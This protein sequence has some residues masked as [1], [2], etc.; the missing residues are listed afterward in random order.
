MIVLII[1]NLLEVIDS[2]KSFLRRIYFFR[3]SRKIAHLTSSVNYHVAI[4]C[5]FDTNPRPDIGNLIEHLRKSGFRVLGVCANNAYLQ[6]KDIL[7][8]VVHIAPVGRDFYAYQQGWIAL[9][10]IGALK[11][12][13]SVT[14]LND[15]VWYFNSQQK[16]TVNNLFEKLKEDQLVV[17]S[18]IYDE[19]PHCSG[20]LFGTSLNRNTRDEIES[21]FKYNFARKSRLYNIRTGEHRILNTLKSV[22][23]I[24]R[25]DGCEDSLPYASCYRALINGDSCFYLKGDATLRTNPAATNMVKFL[26]LNTIQLEF[27]QVLQWLSLQA[28]TSSQCWTRMLEI[29]RYRRHYFK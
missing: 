7:N 9:K 4:F 24:H 11:S 23:G 8:D 12:A 29:S 21:L 19:I 18:V 10:S 6:F 14:F 22:S 5:L 1:N 13:H 3:F 15:S 20:W 17:G 16:T 27:F 28:L 26:K 2:I 25:L